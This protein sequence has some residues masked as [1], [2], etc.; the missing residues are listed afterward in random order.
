MVGEWKG[1]GANRGVAQPTV[2]APPTD[3]IRTAIASAMVV[4]CS[5]RVEGEGLA[6]VEIEGAGTTVYAGT[7]PDLCY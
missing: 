1:T 4:T 2:Y 7:R 3:R 6:R 5:L